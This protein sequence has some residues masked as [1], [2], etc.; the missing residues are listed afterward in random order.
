MKTE[1]SIEIDRPIGDVFRLT[2]D[3]VA[4]WSIIVVEDDLIDETPDGVGTTF[5]TVTEERGQRMVF[6]GVITRHDPPHLNAI[7]LRGDSF[8]IDAEYTFE[9]LSGR[10]RVT[11]RSSVTAKGWFKIFLLLFG[12]VMR[13][14]SCDAASQELE[15]LKRFCESQPDSVT[16]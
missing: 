5:R 14:S 2:N 7:H 4:E 13:K 15:S 16:S 1:S 10:T 9:D 8:D 12:W 6:E 11:Q 3:H